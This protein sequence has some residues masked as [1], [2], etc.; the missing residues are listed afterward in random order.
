MDRIKYQPFTLLYLKNYEYAHPSVKNLFK[1]INEKHYYSDK[2]NNIISFNNSLIVMGESNTC[3]DNS[4][5]IVNLK[6][7]ATVMI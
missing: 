3:K 7:K 2:K 6:E 4:N 5:F 1:S